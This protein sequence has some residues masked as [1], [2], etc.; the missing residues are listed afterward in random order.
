MRD[1][2]SVTGSSVDHKR[3]DVEQNHAVYH[4]GVAEHVNRSGNEIGLSELTLQFGL[5]LVNLA[6]LRIG[7]T[8]LL[9]FLNLLLQYVRQRTTVT[10]MDSRLH[11]GGS[12]RDTSRQHQSDEPCADL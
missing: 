5:V 3:E 2:N 1:I 10:F 9:L 11:A 8:C 4:I 12:E 7:Q 6:L